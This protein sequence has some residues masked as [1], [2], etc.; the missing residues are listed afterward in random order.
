M[1]IVILG[2][3]SAVV[4]IFPNHRGEFHSV[5]AGA[6]IAG[7]LAPSGAPGWFVLAIFLGTTWLFVRWSRAT[8][9]R[10][11]RELLAWRQQAVAEL[12]MRA[13]VT[14]YYP[15]ALVQSRTL[16]EGAVGDAYVTIG[17]VISGS[18]FGPSAWYDV[19]LRAGE[20]E[21][22]ESLDDKLTRNQVFQEVRRLLVAFENDAR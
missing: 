18:D 3:Y 9:A 6:V 12:G 20:R 7:L 8:H 14:P 19:K 2:G 5:I 10:E 1:M 22:Y 13:P 21:R 4:S 16:V 11:Q 17:R 15:P